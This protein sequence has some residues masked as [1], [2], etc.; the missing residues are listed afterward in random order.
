MSKYP[1]EY[2]ISRPVR[3][4]LPPSEMSISLLYEIEDCPHKWALERADYPQIWD[5]RG[6]PSRVHIPSITGTIVH[7]SVER[8][9][10]ELVKAGCSSM[11]DERVIDVMR[12]LGGYTTV[13]R[14]YIEQATGAYKGNPRMES[15]ID[16]IH[17]SLL[18]S[19]SEIRSKVQL[20]VGRMNLDNIGAPTTKHPTANSAKQR[21]SLPY[22]IHSEV[23]MYVPGLHWKGRADLVILTDSLCELID[24]KTGE[25]NERHEF[26]MRTYALLW[27]KDQV[28]NPTS[29]PANK[30]TLSYL[31]ESVDVSVPTGHSLGTVEHEI[32]ERWNRC[33][34]VLVISPPS[35]RPDTDKCLFCD[36]RHLCEKYWNI[37]I[38]HGCV[39][40]TGKTDLADLEITLMEQF[41]P[42]SW[43]IIVDAGYYSKPGLLAS[44]R[45]PPNHY[46]A[47]CA[48]PKDRLR[49]LNAGVFLAPIQEQS[50]P[51]VTLNSISEVFVMEPRV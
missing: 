46:L 21:G 30:L 24:F 23:D 16:S 44:L 28:L 36:V 12:S 18:A 17:S 38:G 5:G 9:M 8:I 27:Y 39:P 10:G 45:I 4:P 29:R 19:T 15:R 20:M 11:R 26:Q 41:S 42:M 43:N 3:W 48:Q 31:H 2:C 33:L 13:I 51:I 32:L 6:Y 34:G 40:Q 22:G 7:S 47:Q 37:S 14:S 50:S 35:P 1:K 49:I 25:H